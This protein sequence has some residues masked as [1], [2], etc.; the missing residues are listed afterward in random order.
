MITLDQIAEQVQRIY[1]SSVAGEN[2]SPDIEKRE[3]YPLIIQLVNRELNAYDMRSKSYGDIHIPSCIMVTYDNL[4]VSS[5]AH[6][7]YT[8]MP[9]YPI[10]LPRDMGVWSV[11]PASGGNPYIYVH[12]GLMNLLANLPEASLEGNVG[13]SVEGM[14]IVYHEYGGQVGTAVRVQ[15]LVADY[16]TMQPDDPLPIFSD[17][18]S[19]IVLKAVE[20]LKTGGLRPDWQREK[21]LKEFIGD[22][23]S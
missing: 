17:L 15:L 18:E 11:I 16:T 8:E 20:T 6:G 22:K 10:R 4:S 13:Y 7:K 23:S 19:V 5:D 9:A 21:D 12:S 1:A 3:I 14:R 2:V